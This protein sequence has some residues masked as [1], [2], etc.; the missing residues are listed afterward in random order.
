M[1]PRRLPV[2]S[3]VSHMLSQMRMKET[4]PEETVPAWRAGAPL[5]RRVEKS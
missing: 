1:A 5:G 2:E 4:G 3:R